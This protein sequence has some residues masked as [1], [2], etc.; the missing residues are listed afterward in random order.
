M[1]KHIEMKGK[2]RKIEEKGKPA[3]WI[4]RANK[5][6][7]KGDIK[8]WMGKKKTPIPCAGSGRKRSAV[9]VVYLSQQLGD[10]CGVRLFLAKAVHDLTHDIVCA[11]HNGFTG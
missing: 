10:L 2:N 9:I 11:L 6:S 7:K 1:R 5:K 8:H 4:T 3:K